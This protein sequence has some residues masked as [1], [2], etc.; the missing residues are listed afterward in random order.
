[1]TLA[2]CG[3]GNDTNETGYSPDGEAS[4]D[5]DN[6]TAY[7]ESDNNYN[8]EHEYSD[9]AIAHVPGVPLLPAVPTPTGLAAPFAEAAAILPPPVALPVRVRGTQIPDSQLITIDTTSRFQVIEGFGAS[10]AWWAQSIGGW[11]NIQDIMDLLYCREL[12]IGLNIFRYNIAAGFPSNA[13]DP[14]R[15]QATVEV[16]PGVYDLTLDE[17]A[18]HVFRLAVERGANRNVAFAKSPPS[19]MTVSGLTSGHWLP[20]T[21]NLQEGYEAAFA[22]Y[23]V[24]ITL[25]LLDEGLP[26]RYISPINEPQWAWGGVYASQEGAFFYPEQVVTMTRALVHEIENRGLRYNLRAS[27]AESGTWNDWDYT[28]NMYRE[29]MADPVIAN[30]L[31]HFAVHSYW[32]SEMDKRRAALFFQGIPDM[33]PLK[34]TEWCEMEWGM[35]LGM[36]AALVL[37]RDMHDNL[38]ILDV[39]SWSHWLAVS[40]YDYRDGLI[41]VDIGTQEFT[42]SKRM[43]AMGNFSRFVRDGFVRVDTGLGRSLRNLLVSAYQSPDASELVLV[44]IN[45]EDEP[46]TIGVDVFGYGYTYVHITDETRDIR[47]VYERLDDVWEYVIPPRSVVTFVNRR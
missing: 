31:T 37:A 46:R 45:P 22:R 42:C 32:S 27:V 25:L 8:G 20:F 30:H 35:D 16:S 26:V 29:L 23:L 34:Q 12:G 39:V 11:D 4:Y 40:R 21:P 17:N 19:R 41:Y 28:L 3:A 18:L 15:S 24:D 38:T 5:L 7:T 13:R 36:D 9:D 33:L 14:W 1:M 43:W 6:S 44:V 10:G 2:S 47:A